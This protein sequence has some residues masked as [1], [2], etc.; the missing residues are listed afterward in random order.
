M[1][2]LEKIRKLLNSLP[3]S[4]QALGES[5]VRDRDF[6]SLKELVDSAFH[7]TRRA[8]KSENPKQEYLDVDLDSLS[9]LK[10]E[11]DLYLTYFETEEI[12]TE[13]ACYEEY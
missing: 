3:E 8:L 5:F 13:R 2:H 7:K 4:D 11:V 10:A 1:K 9:N 12:N 6:D